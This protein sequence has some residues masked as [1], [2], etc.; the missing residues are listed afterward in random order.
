MPIVTGVYNILVEYTT[1]D[2]L[3]IWMYPLIA[4]C[5]VITTVHII[6]IFCYWG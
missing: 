5:V 6:R 2:F 4:G 1:Q 3:S